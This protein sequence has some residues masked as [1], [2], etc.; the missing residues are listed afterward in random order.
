MEA[1]S[2]L[3][4]QFLHQFQAGEDPELAGAG[5]LDARN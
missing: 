3:L 1:G 2:Q 4:R 5:P